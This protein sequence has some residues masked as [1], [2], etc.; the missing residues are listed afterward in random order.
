M[1]NEGVITMCVSSGLFLM[2]RLTGTKLLH[3]RVFTAFEVE[4]QNPIT[5]EIRRV[6]KMQ[7]SPLPGV[8]P[9]VIVKGDGFSYPVEDDEALLSLYKRV[10]TPQPIEEKEEKDQ[11]NVVRMN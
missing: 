3:P 11:D 7:L 2:G 8:P 10:T 6:P 1:S 9:Y 4:E 5:K